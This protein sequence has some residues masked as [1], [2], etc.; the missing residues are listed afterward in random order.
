MD[1]QDKANVK[2]SE[3]E[4][5]I[6]RGKDIHDDFQRSI[7]TGNKNEAY[8]TKVFKKKIKRSKVF[9]IILFFNWNFIRK[10]SEIIN[11][12]KNQMMNPMKKKNLKRN[13]ILKTIIV[14]HPIKKKKLMKRNV[15]KIVI[16]LFGLEY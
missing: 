5:V 12:E 3:I 10:K 7:G 13:L 11:K 8:L 2:K 15:L 14:M 1:C 6:T 16:L 4:V 9:L